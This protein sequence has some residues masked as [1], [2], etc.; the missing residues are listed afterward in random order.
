MASSSRN[1]MLFSSGDSPNSSAILSGDG[2][3]EGVR[4]IAVILT[5]ANE[6]IASARFL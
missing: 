1:A 3:D 2:L 5:A 4:R 6:Q